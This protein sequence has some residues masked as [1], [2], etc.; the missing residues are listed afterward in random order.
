MMVSIMKF[1]QYDVV[2]IVGFNVHQVVFSDESNIRYPAAGDIAPS[3]K[4][5]HRL[6]ITTWNA[7][8][9]TVLNN[10]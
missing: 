9:R 4:F 2:K 8:M 6:W 5:T 3:L 10:G 7:V 1:M